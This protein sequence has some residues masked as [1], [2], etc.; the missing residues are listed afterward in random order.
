VPGAVTLDPAT[1]TLFSP[2]TAQNVMNGETYGVELAATWQPTDWW[3]LHGAYTFLEMQ[4]HSELAAVDSQEIGREGGSPE[5]QV[6]LQS[7]WDLPRNIEFDLTG[8]FVDRLR[9]FNP[10]GAPGIT[11][12][13]DDYI[14]L[15]ARLAWKLHN[16]LEITV[17]G[18]NLLDDHHPE[19]GTSTSIRAPLVEIQRGVKGRWYGVFKGATAPVAKLGPRSAAWLVLS[20]LL[21]SGGPNLSAETPP[22]REYQLKAV[23]LFN[24][25]QFVEWPPEAFPDAQAPLVIGVLRRDPFGA[26]LDE[27]VRGETMN[28]RP[29][30]TAMLWPPSG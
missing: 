22:P 26:Y 12:V 10:G 6:Y 4:L 1:G 28:N 13:I 15:D 24:F 11:D 16:N 27:T 2:V 7:S 19:S 21:L 9:G 29:L 14:S 30:V 23:F 3:R 20:A 8:R 18:Q 25:A 17:V 5:K